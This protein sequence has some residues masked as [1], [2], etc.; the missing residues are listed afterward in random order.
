MIVLEDPD[1]MRRNCYPLRRRRRRRRVVPLPPLSRRRTVGLSA[2]PLIDAVARRRVKRRRR[3]RPLRRYGTTVVTPRRSYRYKRRRAVVSGKPLASRITLPRP[4]LFASHHHFNRLQPSTTIPRGIWGP[5]LNGSRVPTAGWTSTLASAIVPPGSSSLPSARRRLPLGLWGPPTAGS[6]QPTTNWTPGSR[7]FIVE[8][9]AMDDERS[10][11]DVPAAV[12]IEDDSSD[13]GEYYDANGSPMGERSS[14]AR[15]PDGAYMNTDVS[16][17]TP[18]VIAGPSSSSSV[19]PYGGFASDESALG[20]NAHNIIIKIGDKVIYG[21]GTTSASNGNDTIT[22]PAPVP[23]VTG[24]RSWLSLVPWSS[25]SSYV[26]RLILTTVF[27]SVV[28]FLVDWYV[29]GGAASRAARWVIQLL[30]R[31]PSGGG[32]PPIVEAIQRQRAAPGDFDLAPSAEQR[33]G[34]PSLWTSFL[35]SLRVLA[36]F[37]TLD[38]VRPGVATAGAAAAAAAAAGGVVAEGGLGGLLDALSEI[39]RNVL[40]PQQLVRHTENLAR[41]IDPRQLAA[42]LYPSGWTADA[43]ERLSLGA[44]LYGLRVR[45][46]VRGPIR[47]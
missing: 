38:N 40:D 21:P 24:V 20:P 36:G 39:V 44:T 41:A 19:R 45:D 9:H 8:R 33:G 5:P 2:G 43:A 3:R 25:F 32:L 14:S 16:V 6:L 29:L 15:P 10:S 27:G 1:V 30:F 42:Y 28:G 37:H 12:A 7:P 26:R 47:D 17:P 11:N 18:P 23:S 4:P 13:E 22:L 35:N 34:A 46:L 31:V